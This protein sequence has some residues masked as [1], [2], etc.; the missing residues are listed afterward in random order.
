[1]LGACVCLA[2]HETLINC[3]KE[4]TECSS[5]SSLSHFIHKQ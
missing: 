5:A 1:M 4:V 2:Y 3:I